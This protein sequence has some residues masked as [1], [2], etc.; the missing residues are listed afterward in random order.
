MFVKL[1]DN[2]KLTFGKS[3]PFTLHGNIIYEVIN[4]SDYVDKPCLILL[5]LD[6]HKKQYV[7]VFDFRELIKKNILGICDENGDL[8]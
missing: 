8:I 6:R 7:T 3:L 4:T 2:R 5:S 1:T